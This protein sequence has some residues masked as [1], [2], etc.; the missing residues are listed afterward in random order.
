MTNQA[1]RDEPSCA[2]AS[3]IAL[4]EYAAKFLLI[5]PQRF[6]GWTDH[7]EKATQSTWKAY[8]CPYKA[9][10]AVAAIAF[11]ALLMALVEAQKEHA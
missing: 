11:F 10:D 4:A 6:S 7:E 3:W 1:L 5:G 9:R 8:G 2:R